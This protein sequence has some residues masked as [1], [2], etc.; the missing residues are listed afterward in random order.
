VKGD[1][2]GRA[3][4]FLGKHRA[5]SAAAPIC[6]L[7]FQSGPAGALELVSCGEEGRLCRFDVFGSSVE[8]GV[9]LLAVSDEALGGPAAGGTVGLVQAVSS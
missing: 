9:K 2:A 7:A 4:E 8:G 5:H 3:F 1:E 6:G